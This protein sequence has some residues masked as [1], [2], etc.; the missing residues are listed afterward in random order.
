MKFWLNHHRSIY[1]NEPR[2]RM[3]ITGFR[4]SREILLSY[5][6]TNGWAQTLATNLVIWM[7][8]VVSPEFS[9]VYVIIIFSLP[10]LMVRFSSRPSCLVSWSFRSSTVMPEQPSWNVFNKGDKGNI[11]LVQ[12]ISTF[13]NRPVL[14]NS[15]LGIKINFN[16]RAA[17]KNN[18]NICWARYKNI[19]RVEGWG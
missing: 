2:R 6:L 15:I 5:T 19:L 16:L 8:F 17:G 11:G 9:Q 4:Y 1:N 7:Q 10:I 18:E 13:Q 12:Q 14:N 3:K